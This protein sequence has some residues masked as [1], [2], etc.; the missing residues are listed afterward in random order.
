MEHMTLPQRAL[1]RIA[2]AF[3]VLEIGV[4]AFR[5][6][7]DPQNAPAPLCLA[8]LFAYFAL[9]LMSFVKERRKGASDA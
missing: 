6:D 3:G 4:Q 9:S 8:L 5:P 2:L 7:L 1:W